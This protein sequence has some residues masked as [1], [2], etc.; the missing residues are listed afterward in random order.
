MALIE[1]NSDKK[2]LIGVIELVFAI[3]LMITSFVVVFLLLSN[4][5]IE[6]AY[7][8]IIPAIIF[9]SWVILKPDIV[10]FE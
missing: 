4:Y 3:L 2:R 7:V 10:E 6:I 8:S 9:I 1:I 5:S